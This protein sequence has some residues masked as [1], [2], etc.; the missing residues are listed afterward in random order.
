M[1]TEERRAAIARSVQLTE[2]G[3][4]IDLR[5]HIYPDGGVWL[6][7]PTLGND[8]NFARSSQEAMIEDLEAILSEARALIQQAHP[9][10]A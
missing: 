1:T 3:G 2:K 8:A 4:R 10:K 9:V 7:S 5:F 6:H